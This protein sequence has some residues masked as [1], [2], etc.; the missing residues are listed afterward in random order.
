MKTRLT[1]WRRIRYAVFVALFLSL[2]ATYWTYSYETSPSANEMQVVEHPYQ[3]YTGLLVVVSALMF[4]LYVLSGYLESKQ[5]L[6]FNYH[7][8]VEGID[9]INQVLAE[10]DVLLNPS[11]Y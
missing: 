10:K 7:E 1:V 8:L 2:L 11:Q 3:T 4:C 6:D 5:G 9:R